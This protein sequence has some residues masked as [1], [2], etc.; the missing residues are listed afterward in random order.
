MKSTAPQGPTISLSSNFISN[1]TRLLKVTESLEG[2]SFSSPN[3]ATPDTNTMLSGGVL[4]NLNDPVLDSQGATYAY[5][6]AHGGTANPGGPLNS[7]QYNDSGAFGGSS[8]L[9]F[10]SGTNTLTTNKISNGTVTIGSNTISGLTDPTIGSEAATKNYVDN[11]TAITITTINTVGSV[12]YPVV[13][14]MNGLILRDTQTTGTTTDTLPTAAQI[15]ATSGAIVGTTLYFSIRNASSDLTNVV[16]FNTGTGITM[17]APMNIFSGYQYNGVMIVTNIGSGTEA[18]TLYFINNSRTDTVNWEVELGGLASVVDVVNVTDYLLI[19]NSVSDLSPPVSAKINTND[20][21]NKVIIYSNVVPSMVSM[22]KPDSFM[23]VITGSDFI[24]SPF[25]WTTG[26]MDFYLM[27]TSTVPGADLTLSGITG[28]IGWTLDPNSN[29]KIPPG[30][31]GW[32]MVVL[33][34]TNYPQVSSL[35][36]ASVYTLG[37]FSSS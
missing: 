1:F 13:A 14:V 27:N 15:V 5:A 19:F 8:S 26:G 25:I 21:S 16:T 10:N 22:N 30:Y 36:S 34:V 9:L 28:T 2:N 24:T 11:Y 6:L 32:F 33:E 29:M 18:L 31:T 3:P 4:S 17:A 37:I 7:V 12:T 35:L 23:G 20:V